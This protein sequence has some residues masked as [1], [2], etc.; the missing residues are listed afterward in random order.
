MDLVGF[1]L[2]MSILWVVDGEVVDS[3]W[4]IAKRF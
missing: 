4:R 3:V 2:R 1:R